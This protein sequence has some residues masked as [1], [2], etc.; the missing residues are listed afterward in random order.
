MIF[1]CSTLR[2]IYY[3][4]HLWKSLSS[5]GP[6][7]SCPSKNYTRIIEGQ[8]CC[9]IHGCHL[10]VGQSLNKGDF[11][12]EEELEVWVEVSL[13]HASLRQ[14]TLVL[15]VPWLTAPLG[16]KMIFNHL[17]ATLA[18]I[19]CPSRQS[20]LQPAACS[21]ENSQAVYVAEPIH[22]DSAETKPRQD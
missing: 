5:C 8:L 20:S 22:P 7:P 16:N 4:C 15:L 2:F 21:G 14:R 19:C 10:P 9:V 3:D 1:N 13:S 12:K 18:T 11:R 6:L 17:L